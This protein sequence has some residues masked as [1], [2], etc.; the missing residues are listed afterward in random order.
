MCVVSRHAAHYVIFAHEEPVR[1]STNPGMNI[2]CKTLRQ[3]KPDA[4]PRTVLECLARNEVKIT[5]AAQRDWRERDQ[6]VSLRQCD[7]VSAQGRLTVATPT[8]SCNP[9]NKDTERLAG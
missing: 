9:Q 8:D 6:V 2:D 1:G 5:D 7:S 3:I 4:A